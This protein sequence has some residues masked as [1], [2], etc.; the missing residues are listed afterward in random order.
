MLLI[1]PSPRLDMDQNID[2]Q[3]FDLLLLQL[4]F[5]YEV[6]T[7]DKP[8]PQQQ[9]LSLTYACQLDASSFG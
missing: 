4:K 1:Q 9:I 2:K 5:E 8:S 6:A 7:S 3:A